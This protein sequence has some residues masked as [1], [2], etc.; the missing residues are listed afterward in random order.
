M[1]FFNKSKMMVLPHYKTGVLHYKPIKKAEFRPYI[2][3][4]PNFHGNRVSIVV[5][6]MSGKELGGVYCNSLPDLM[7]VNVPLLQVDMHNAVTNQ[8]WIEPVVLE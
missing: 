6:T 8:R 7:A 3:Y 4:E 1:D 5:T 2:E